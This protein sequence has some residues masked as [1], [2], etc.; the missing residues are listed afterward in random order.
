MPNT[1]GNI[2]VIARELGR[3]LAPLQEL[4][5][6]SDIL[7]SLGMGLPE[8]FRARPAIAGVFAQGQTLARQLTGQIEALVQATG[9][10]QPG[11]MV[12]AGAD[13]LQTV[14]NLIRL[15]EQLGTTLAAEANAFTFTAAERAE[16]QSFGGTFAR[17]LVNYLLVGYLVDRAPTLANSLMVLGLLDDETVKSDPARPLQVPHRKRVVYFDRIPALFSD[18]GPHFAAVF[19]WGT[20]AF[21]GEKLLKR[22]KLVL[23]ALDFPSHL[24][25]LG[26]K[27]VL[28]A[29]VFHLQVDPSETPPGLEL[30]LRIPAAVEVTREFLFAPP[31]KATLTTRGTFSAGLAASVFPSGTVA[32][33][34]PE[35]S[36]VFEA[37][38]GLVAGYPDRKVIFIGA[39][40]GSRLEAQSL[41]GSVGAILRVNP[42]AGEAFSEPRI[43]VFL[44]GGKLVLDM[45]NSDGFLSTILSGVNV[46]ADFNLDGTWSPAAGLQLTGNAGLEIQLPVHLDLGIARIDSIYL[47]GRVGGNPPLAVELS[48]QLTANLGPLR[49]SVDR[50]GVNVPVAFPANADG[51]LG[52]IDLRFAFKPPNGVGLS[53]DAGVVKGGGYLFFDFDRGEYAGALELVFSEWIALKAIGL[54]TTRLPDGSSGFSLLVIISV[55]FGTGIQLGLGFTL[56]GVGGLLGL[57]RTVNIDPLR[58][59]VRTGAVESVMFPRNVV[60]NAPRLISDLR[61]FF[62]TVQ[63][64]FLVGPMAKI[65]W[66]TPTLAS[67]SLGVIVEFPN[68]TL[69]ILGVVKV[70]LPH[71]NAAVLR[72]QVN[73]V[74][75]IEPANQLLWFYAELYDSRVLFMTLEGGMGLLVKWGD[76]PNF[77]LSVGGFHPRYTP[78]PLP[79]PAPPRIAVSL[80]STP[81]ARV[82]IEGYFAVTSNSAQFGARVEVFI[83]VSAFRVEGHLSFDALFRFDPFYFS[84]D[85]SVSLS[86]K[87]FGVG[88]FSVRFTGLLEGPT[89]WHLRGEGHISLLFFD[90]S[91]PFE[92]TWGESTQTQLEP[93]KVQPLIET[94]VNALTNWEALLPAG[95]G[96][97]VSL[98]KLGSGD[99]GTLVFHPVGQLRISQR[100]I[101]LNLRL[102]RVGSQKP[103]DVNHLSLSVDPDGAWQMVRQVREPFALGQFKDLDDAQKLSSPGFVPCDS[104]LLVS[105]KGAQ[106]RTSK[107]VRRVIRYETVILDNNY[108]RQPIRFF[109]FFKQPGLGTLHGTLFGHHL[110]GGAVSQSTLSKHHR[111]RMQ[112][113]EDAVRVQPNGYSVA[114]SANNQPFTDAA[115]QFTSRAAADDFLQKELLRDPN[116]ADS[117]HIIP[118]TEIAFA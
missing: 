80:L 83:G 3:V 98:R 54:V 50:V 63:D 88:L 104:G 15:L 41:G 62:P 73:F 103:A 2:E 84:F 48:T 117:L 99:A 111:K 35:A 116:L 90:I 51:N 40:G 82:R 97:R 69:T 21:N 39:A 106:L 113:F 118:N 4:L 91:V 55:E 17:R 86:V 20:N 56:L 34:P 74:G 105:A 87:V 52:P 23:D 33:A 46:Q 16:L 36:L 92:V 81:L 75:R 68:V 22:V 107:A 9:A 72:L 43:A 58:E 78:P 65:G 101:P 10:G 19:D 95:A 24:Y 5:G 85:L 13:L 18:P 71:E 77:V 53:V 108:K 12:D 44:H 76:Q 115:T 70:T 93:I 37:N 45:S 28:E 96:L 59:A 14:L 29:Y 100:K 112:P 49:A 89:P 94:E 26:G 79:F 1:P 38:L 30:E 110:A 25:P 60:E 67:V 42:P 32:V 8:A 11:D 66:G 57:H 102:D 31:W 64:Q 6:N 27:Y 7:Q 109:K 61:R 114:F 47:I